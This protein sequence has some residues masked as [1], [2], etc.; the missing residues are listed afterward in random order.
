MRKK[1]HAW[2]TVVRSD[3]AHGMVIDYMYQGGLGGP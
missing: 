2:Y 3:H 1:T